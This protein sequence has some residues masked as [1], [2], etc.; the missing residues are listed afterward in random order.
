MKKITAILI[1]SI[2]LTTQACNSNSGGSEK[3]SVDT[4]ND[5]NATKDTTNMSDTK[6][7]TV[8][9]AMSVNDD[10]AKFAVKVAN[11][12]MMEVA[13]GKLAEQKS[14]NAKIK[15]FGSMMVK[16]HTNANDKLKEIATQKN[17]SLPSSISQ[18]DQKHIDD[19]SKENE[20]DFDKD[21]IDMMVKDHKDN[22][23]LFEGAA[24]NSS[25]STFKNFAAKTLPTLYKHLGAA[26]AI[27][28]TRQ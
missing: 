13:L 18:D 17:I 23:D 10:V 1:A 8:V 19:L 2:L 9:N 7:D 22:I 27:Q 5:A 4:A 6:K 20:K 12:G 11:G 26:K 24:K 25:D 16:D 28:K 15:D 14:A 21:Y 3:D